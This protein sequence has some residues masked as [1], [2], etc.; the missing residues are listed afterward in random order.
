MLKRG[1]Q[2]ADGRQGWQGRGNNCNTFLFTNVLR[3][4]QP[5]IIIDPGHTTNE[6]RE[7]CFSYLTKAIEADGFK[8]GDIGLIIKLVHVLIH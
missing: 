1:W 2:L 5:H 6:A 7:D 3:G 4:E 8:I